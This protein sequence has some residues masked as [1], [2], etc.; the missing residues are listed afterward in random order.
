VQLGEAEERE[1]RV[2]FGLCAMYNTSN[3]NNHNKNIREWIIIRGRWVDELAS[4]RGLIFL[5]TIE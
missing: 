2:D 5:V 1:E 4:R 3:N